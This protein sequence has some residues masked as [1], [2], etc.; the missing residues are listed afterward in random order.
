MGLTISGER[1]SKDLMRRMQIHVTLDQKSM[2][3]LQV[4]LPSALIQ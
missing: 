4:F 2:S 1:Y 3:D